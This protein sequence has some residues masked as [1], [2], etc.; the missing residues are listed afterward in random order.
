MFNYFG[1]GMAGCDDAVA[2]D[3]GKGVFD[4][5]ELRYLGQDGGDVAAVL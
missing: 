4:D 2:E 5:V 1:L 3:V